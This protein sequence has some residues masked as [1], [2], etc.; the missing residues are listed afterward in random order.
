M[1]GVPK[2]VHSAP[3]R[4]FFLLERLPEKEQS[5]AVFEISNQCGN[6]HQSLVI[7]AL[8]AAR[9]WP[10][11]M[12]NVFYA[13]SLHLAEMERGHA[14]DL[15]WIWVLQGSFLVLSVLQMIWSALRLALPKPSKSSTFLP[16]GA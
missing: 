15:Q 8:K 10:S 4:C 13:A 12:A 16:I 5:A 1:P 14:V 6:H 3:F 2:R 11:N 7:L 9:P